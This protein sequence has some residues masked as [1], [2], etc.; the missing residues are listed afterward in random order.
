MFWD[1]ITAEALVTKHYQDFLPWWHH[2]DNFVKR[3]DALRPMLMHRFGGMYL[4]LDV[5]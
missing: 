3:S 4:D 1:N 5:E 2:Y